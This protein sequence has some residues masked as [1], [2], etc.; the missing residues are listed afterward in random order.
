MSGGELILFALHPS[1]AFGE[2][3]A[4][5]LGV[6]LADH[7]ERE[8]ED[9]EFKVRTLVPV[10]GDD[11]YVV[12]SLYGE[13]GASASDKLVRLA[14]FVGAL[15]DA[16]AGRVTAV[17]PYLAFSR[18]DRRTKAFDPVNTRY[19][20]EIL[21]AVGI[22]R[23][24]T[25]DVHNEAAYENAFRVPAEHLELRAL[26]AD[27]LVR[28]WPDADLAVVSPDAGGMKRAEALRQ[29]LAGTLDRPVGMAFLEKYRSDDLVSGTTLV[30][31]VDGRLAVIVDDLIASGSTLAR[32]AAACRTAGATAVVGAATHGLFTGE[33]GRHLGPAHL[34]RLV[35][36]DTVPPFR[37]DPDGP[38]A[39]RLVILPAHEVFA[40]AIGRLY[41]D[42]SLADLA[43]AV[44]GGARTRRGGDRE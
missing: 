18:K 28:T 38:L 2:R 15:R 40:A 3:V 22:D 21:E 19:V 9:G 4:A 16:G 42:E 36:G 43:H 44:P 27:H 20:A 1:R 17:T 14:F 29:A 11:V 23:V 25:M 32:A 41:A 34:D 13:P 12:H 39:R 5:A 33:A 31:D 7:E 37:L 6:H 8:F 35:T 30:G 26:L 24:V 10:R